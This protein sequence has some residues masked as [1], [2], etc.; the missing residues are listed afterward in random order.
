M[1]RTGNDDI[2][3][4]STKFSLLAKKVD[5]VSSSAEPAAKRSKTA[6]RAKATAGGSDAANSSGEY[7]EIARGLWTYK[8]WEMSTWGPT[9][10][11]VEVCVEWQRRGLG[12]RFYR[13]ME[14]QMLVPF[15]GVG[16]IISQSGLNLSVCQCTSEHAARFFLSSC[17]FE[18]RDGMMEELGK[19]V[20]WDADAEEWLP[21]EEAEENGLRAVAELDSAVL[22][23]KIAQM[24]PQ[25]NVANRIDMQ[26]MPVRGRHRK[27]CTRCGHKFGQGTLHGDEEWSYTS[28]RPGGDKFCAPCML[29]ELREWE[30][31]DDDEEEEEE[32]GEDV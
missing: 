2:F 11:N 4:V 17:G 9:L 10:E 8:N 21:D 28:P 18:D 3:R 5:M 20:L 31:G 29:D 14:E 30:G 26:R 6:S 23:L 27:D 16:G 19:T 32:D 25:Y 12:T 7:H 1:W 15:R 13:A 22:N 24:L